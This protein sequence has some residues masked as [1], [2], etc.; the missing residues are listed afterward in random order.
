MTITVRLTAAEERS[1]RETVRIHSATRSDVVRLA[2]AQ[3][4]QERLREG[5]RRAYDDIAQW[6]GCAHSGK[7]DL[8]TGAHKLYRERIHAGRRGHFR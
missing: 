2:I 6:I 3:Y 7:G 8:A 1:L 4:C 5:K